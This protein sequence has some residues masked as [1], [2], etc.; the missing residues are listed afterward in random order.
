MARTCMLARNAAPSCPSGA[1]LYVMVF[2]NVPF[3]GTSS[4]EVANKVGSQALKYP[5]TPISCNLRML[6]RR[7]LEK[8]L[9][10]RITLNEILD[11]PWVTGE[12]FFEVCGLKLGRWKGR[13]QEAGMGLKWT[14]WICILDKLCTITLSSMHRHPRSPIVLSMAGCLR[15]KKTAHAKAAVVFGMVLDAHCLQ[16][17]PSPQSR[18]LKPRGNDPESLFE[19]PSSGREALRRVAARGGLG[20][21]GGGGGRAACQRSREKGRTHARRAK[22]LRGG[23]GGAQISAV[24]KRHS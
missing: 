6:M 13:M 8:D 5:D 23:Q 16:S 4:E 20:Q 15:E 10:H 12:S 19:D 7:M 1:T 22:W 9:L 2:G 18:R 11:D 14:W 17:A 3:Q 21:C 24:G